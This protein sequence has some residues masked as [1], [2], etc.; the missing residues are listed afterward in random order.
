[1][2][3]SPMYTFTARGSNAFSTDEGKI[4]KVECRGY[5]KGGQ[6]TP[7]ERRPAIDCKVTQVAPEKPTDKAIPMSTPA[8]TTSTGK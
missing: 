4:S 8:P 6:N 2:H 3:L 1:M 5:E 7:M